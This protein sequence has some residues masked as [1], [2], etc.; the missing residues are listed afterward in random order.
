MQNKSQPV[1][2]D[3]DE[4]RWALIRDVAVL[5]AKLIVDGVRDLLLVP[6]SILAGIVSLVKSDFSAGNEF[7]ELMRLGKKSEHWINLF[8]AADQLPDRD[9]DYVN[10][11]DEDI[12]AIVTRVETFVVNEYRKGGVTRQAKERIDKAI[13]SLHKLASA[14]GSKESSDD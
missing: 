5:Q 10:F 1:N 9:H 13:T 8:G 2:T 11:P 12:D 14:K 3:G 4:D 7:Y 6:I